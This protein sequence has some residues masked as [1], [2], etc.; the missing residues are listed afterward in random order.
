MK[1]KLLCVLLTGVMALSLVACGSGKSA[2][3]SAGSEKITALEDLKGKTVGVQTGTTGDIYISDDKD[4]GIKSV[5]H[6]NKGF[7]AVQALLQG[8]IDAVVI[9]DQPA[10]TFVSDN[11]EELTTLDTA[12]TEEDYAIAIAKDNEDLLNKVNGAIEALKADGTL[13]LIVNHYINGEEANY[14]PKTDLKHANGTLVMATNAEFP[15][16]EYHEDNKIVGL[17]ADFG[18][19]IAD[20][21]DM[22]LR[23]E[24]MSFDSI[25][26]AVQGGKADIGMAGMTVTEERQQ[27]INF[28][29]S[30]YTGRQ[31]VI[32]KK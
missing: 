30:Y 13:E 1:K 15:P 16:Y 19:A 20:Y 25:I 5:E 21:L 23:I 4:L 11:A 17:D 14:E 32:V 18:Q 12:Y 8:K 26:S 10:R 6:Y 22:E 27:S 7:E 9:D 29:Q 3:E 2:S 24:D 28:S 31:V